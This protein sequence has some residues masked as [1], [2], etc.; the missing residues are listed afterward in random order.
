MMRGELLLAQSDGLFDLIGKGPHILSSGI[1]VPGGFGERGT[2]GMI[3]AIKWAREQNRA[4]L[5]ICLGFQLA[6]VEWARHVVNL[7]GPQY[8]LPS[9]THYVDFMQA[10]SQLSSFQTQLIQS[11]YSCP[12]S[13]VLT[14]VERCASGCAQQ[15]SKKIV[16]GLAYVSSMVE[17]VLYGSAIVTVTR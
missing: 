17:L 10:L 13:R 9:S 1:L 2:E 16:N 5:G 6:V 4:F 11:S 12:K 8:F 3:L 7:P 15:C 14:W